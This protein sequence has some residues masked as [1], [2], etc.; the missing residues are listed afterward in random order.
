MCLC[1]CGKD[2]HLKMGCWF[3]F[4]KVNKIIFNSPPPKK[5][6]N[7]KRKESQSTEKEA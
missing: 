5:R 4:G 6:K 2:A 3:S 7:E 1:V